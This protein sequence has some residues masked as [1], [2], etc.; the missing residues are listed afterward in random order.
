MAVANSLA[1]YVTATIKTVKSFIVQAPGYG[2]KVNKNFILYDIL[3]SIFLT[4]PR[5]NFS[6]SCSSKLSSLNEMCF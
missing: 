6:F 2:M 4:S 3:Y 1:Y 5:N